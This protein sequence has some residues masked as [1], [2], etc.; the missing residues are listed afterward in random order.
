MQR[1]KGDHMNLSYL[2]KKTVKPM[3]YQGQI[4]ASYFLGQNNHA[5]KK[6]GVNRV[7]LTGWVIQTKRAHMFI[8]VKDINHNMDIFK[9]MHLNMPVQSIY[10]KESTG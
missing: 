1:V 10:L 5:Q 7:G 6:K 2:K 9:M 4:V 8:R 3:S